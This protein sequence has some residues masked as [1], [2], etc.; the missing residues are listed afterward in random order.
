MSM[1]SSGSSERPTVNLWRGEVEEKGCRGGLGPLLA[2]QCWWVGTRKTGKIEP[3][4]QE[5][6]K[7]CKIHKSCAR[8]L[9]YYFLQQWF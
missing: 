8:A 2:Q 1:A 6:E 7:I 4:P 3:P 5:H 9:G